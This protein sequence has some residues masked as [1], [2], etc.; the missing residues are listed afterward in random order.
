MEST[1]FAKRGCTA[2]SK[3][4]E[5]MCLCATLKDFYC[6]R[7]FACCVFEIACV[8]VV[9]L[10]AWAPVRIDVYGVSEYE[11]ECVRACVRACVRVCIA[12]VHA[13]MLTR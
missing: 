2:Q 7:V 11:Y 1:G 6:S 4:T 12:Y 13:C 3:S 9:C 8:S 5:K 10:C